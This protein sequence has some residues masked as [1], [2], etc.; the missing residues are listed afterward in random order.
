VTVCVLA[1]ALVRGGRA[2]SSAWVCARH[3]QR[4]PELREPAGVCAFFRLDA[5]FHA[6]EPHPR[7]DLRPGACARAL[8]CLPKKRMKGGETEKVRLRCAFVIIC[9]TSLFFL[10]HQYRCG[11]FCGTT[12]CRTAT[13]TTKGSRPSARYA[14]LHL[15]RNALFSSSTR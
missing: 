12:N 7:L 3:A 11:S 9:P 8:V 14:A 1:C 5:P 6:G 4:R 15:L 10:I 2:R 13:F